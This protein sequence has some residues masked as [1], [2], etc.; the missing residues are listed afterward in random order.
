MTDN[1]EKTG[2]AWKEQL[3]PGHF[4]LQQLGSAEIRLEM[5]AANVTPRMDNRVATDDNCAL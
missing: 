4:H 2:Q 1:I 3:T 5:S